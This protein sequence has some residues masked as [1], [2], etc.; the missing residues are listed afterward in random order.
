MIKFVNNII[1][2]LNLIPISVVPRFVTFL[3]V[4]IGMALGTIIG[5]HLHQEYQLLTSTSID[6]FYRMIIENGLLNIL[7]A[8]VIGGLIERRK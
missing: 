7:I 2:A 6:T 3:A 5:V 1:S 4:Y 8:F